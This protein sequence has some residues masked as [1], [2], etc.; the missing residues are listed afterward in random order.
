LLSI[1][2]SCA[3]SGLSYQCALFCCCHTY[4][5]QHERKKTMR[6]SRL[7]YVMLMCLRGC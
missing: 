1:E 3:M 4:R 6:S 2:A 7:N 5:R